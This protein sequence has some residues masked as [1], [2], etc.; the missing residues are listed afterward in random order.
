MSVRFRT[1]AALAGT[2]ALAAPAL[3]QSVTGLSNW[4]I[5]LD[6][7][8]SQTENQGVFGYSEAEKTLA[9]GLELRRLLT[10]LTDVRAVYMTRTDGNEVVSLSQRTAYANSTGASYFHSIH[11]NAAAASA[12]SGFVLWAQMPDGSEPQ[13]P[14]AG[15]RR[16]AQT[17]GPTVG[18]A[19][20]IPLSNGGAWGECDFYGAGTCGSGVKGSR[21]AV[22][23]GTLMPSTLSEMGFHTNPT[24]NQRNMNADWKRMEARAFFWSILKYHNIPRPAGRFLTGI[25][26]DVESGLPVNGATVEFAG[27][28]Y[29]TDTYASLFS[30]FSNDPNELRNGYYYLE[31]VAPGANPLNVS[32]PGFV[33]KS[34]SVATVDTF[35]TFADVTLV[36]T[37][38]VTVTATT[39]AANGSNVRVVDP[40]SVTFSRPVDPATVEAAWSLAPAAGGAAVAGTFA[41][42]NGNRTAVFRPAASLAAF[43]QYR[44]T[45][46]GTAASPYGFALDGNADGTA[47]DAFARTFTTGAQDV[48]GPVAAQFWPS[49]AT[50]N[51]S[52]TPLLSVTFDELVDRASITAGSVTLLNHALNT[53]VA[54][55]TA[56]YDV[57]GQTVVNVV[58]EAPLAPKT[59][60]RLVVAPGLKDRLGNTA[61]AEARALFQTGTLDEAGATFETFDG[62]V[63]TRWW[64]PAQSGSTTGIVTDS[65]DRFASPVQNPR[66]AATGQSMG[67]R[68]GWDA[69]ATSTLI[70]ACYLGCAGPTA[71]LDTSYTLQMAVFGDGS[72]TRIRFA[73]DDGCT[74]GSCAGSEVGPWTDVTWR[75]WR[76]VEWDLGAVAPPEAWIGTS[77]RVLNGNLRLESLQMAYNATTG[78]AFGQILVDDI[79]AIK[80]V[81]VSS[82]DTPLA[83]NAFALDPPAPNP[84]AGSAR[85]RFTLPDARAV[86][87]AVYDVM[88]REVA[89]LVD[90]TRPAGPHAVE[91]DARG[92]AAGPYLVRLSAGAERRT[93]TVVV[94]R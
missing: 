61:T 84:V 22:Q 36:S 34:V 70:R 82:E 1:V 75:G 10:T 30:R 66:G 38:P 25:V 14:Y 33:N 55:R 69:S 48:V 52:R 54:A 65:T 64:T 9:V 83:A 18:R 42:S 35:F 12:T 67:I 3:A 21:N 26:S 92:L 17:M 47:G 32:A 90:E 6:P 63:T 73:L 39:P 89:V 8:H 53:P 40:I 51:I 62:D 76:L 5:V 46:D 2:L 91:W 23:R 15:G 28:S 68:Y 45:I 29:T 77:N 27:K 43:T 49:N 81:A 11:S 50:S 41:W 19:M 85:L 71:S 31:D 60:Y 79:R 20:R 93:A 78:V 88:G 57:K 87:L 86:R 24:Q 58:P 44:L 56:V 7:G 13:P 59:V 74:G 94:Q 16:M 80:T 4:S 72:G 37:A